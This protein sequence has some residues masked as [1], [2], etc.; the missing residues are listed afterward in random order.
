MTDPKRFAQLKQK[1]V[2]VEESRMKKIFDA[3]PIARW[4]WRYGCD[5]RCLEKGAGTV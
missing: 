1:N 5:A 2:T 4:E 3:E